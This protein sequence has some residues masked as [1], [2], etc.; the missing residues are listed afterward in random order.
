LSWIKKDFPY[1]AGYEELGDNV[2][3]KSWLSFKL[4]QLLDT[5]DP[6]W[7][8][9]TILKTRRDVCNFVISQF[10]YP[11]VRGRP[12]DVHKNNW[13]GGLCCHQITQDMWQSAS[14]TLRTLRLNQLRGGKGYGDCEDVSVLFVTLI[15][16][17]RHQ[18]YECL[19]YV[20]RDGEVLGGHG[21]AIFQDEDFTWRLYEATLSTPPQYPGGY[22]VVDPEGNDFKVGDVTYHAWAK[23][24]RYEYYEW[25]DG[26]KNYMGLKFKLK[27]TRRKHEA[28]SK[29]FQQKTKPLVRLGFLGK[30]RWK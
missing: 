18:A 5:G 26:M 17:K 12:N 14:E 2:E 27:E 1:I 3:A 16:E 24:N 7:E 29:A 22:P 28:I 13:F 15:L 10:D 23:F 4:N 19:G 20:A 21:W 25:E 8:Y 6:V 9:K 11:M 30:L